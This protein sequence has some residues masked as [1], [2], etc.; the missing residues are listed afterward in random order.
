[1]SPNRCS[2]QTV[3]K[4]VIGTF[5]QLHNDLT[6]AARQAQHILQVIELSDPR[7]G[8]WGLARGSFEEQNRQALGS[9]LFP[10]AEE[11]KVRVPGKRIAPEN[12]EGIPHP[13]V[14]VADC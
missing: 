3:S 13:I 10:M 1:M 2:T 6:I 4:R 14:D 7:F 9:Y 5:D 8:T 12:A 11:A